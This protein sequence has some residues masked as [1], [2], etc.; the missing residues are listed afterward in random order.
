MIRNQL[1]EIKKMEKEARE[2]EG[3]ISLAQGYPDF[4]T[5]WPIIEFVKGHLNDPVWHQYTVSSGLLKLKEEISLFLSRQGEVY[6]PQNEIL[7]TAGANAGLLSVLLSCF[8]PND[9]IALFT[10]TYASYFDQLRIA[11]LNPVYL[12]LK[13][14][15]W[16]IDLDLVKDRIET[17]KPKAILICNPNNP[18]GNLI[19]KSEL[20]E[21]AKIALE[22]N[23]LIICDEVYSF[24]IYENE[25]Y[26]SLAS[27]PE[28]KSNFIK[29]QSF[30]K[31]YAMTGWRIGY[32]CATAEKI[33]KIL[34]VHDMMI[35]CAPSLSQLAAL[36][37]LK[38]GENFVPQFVKEFNQRR[39]FVHFWLNKMQDY[40]Y[41]DKPKATYF[42]F[43][44]LKKPNS[45]FSSEL[46]KEAKVAV[47]KGTAF[48]PF[49]EEY[50]RISFAKN[51]DIL[52]EALRRISNYFNPAL[53]KQIFD[54]NVATLYF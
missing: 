6:N 25:N 21:I 34:T 49:Y 41:A 1:S 26:F 40:I 9:S 2:K 46:L 4:P 32:I 45:N 44:K 8:N 54:E 33:N 38:L 42:Y 29:I 14:D 12:P 51:F 48:G 10:P 53:A 37:A 7:I 23:L 35:N 17:H 43:I 11:G 13:E 39:N 3:V 22:N 47:V 24:L 20:I 16:R 18:T 27:K 28:F 5:P 36:A 52:T 15:G 30:S 50:F 31:R 19:R